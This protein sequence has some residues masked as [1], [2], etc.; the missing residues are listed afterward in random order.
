[1]DLQAEL[2]GFM[3]GSFGVSQLSHPWFVG[4]FHRTLRVNPAA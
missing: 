3:L 2:L 4:L 1:M